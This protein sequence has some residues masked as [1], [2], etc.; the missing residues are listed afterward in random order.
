MPEYFWPQ[1]WLPFDPDFRNVRIHSYGYNSDWADRREDSMSINDFG[2][3]LIEDVHNCPT[4]RRDQDTRIVFIAHSMGGLVVKKAVI[5]SKI[6]PMFRELGERIHALYFF[7]T[8]HRG[9]DLATTLNNFLR[10]TTSPKHFVTNLERGSDTTRV[11][12]DQ[13]RHIYQG[14]ELHS[15]V[16]TVPMT[17]HIGSGLIVDRESATMGESPFKALC[18]H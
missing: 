6:N 16:E 18:R 17:W 8:P 5:T 15:F 14:I 3:A 11:L 10:A 12:N 9:A 2:V 4:I 13:F 7:G 1:A